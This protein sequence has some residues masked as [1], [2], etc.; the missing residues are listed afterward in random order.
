MALWL[1]ICFSL[2]PCCRLL[3][4]VCASVSNRSSVDTGSWSRPLSSL[5]HMELRATPV[6]F[7]LLSCVFLL[8][9]GGS[10]AFKVRGHRLWCVSNTLEIVP[11]RCLNL[12]IL[13]NVELE[14][15][16]SSPGGS[17]SGGPEILAFRFFV[18][19]ARRESC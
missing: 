3:A 11:I 2:P 10:H 12:G 5:H 15:P 8:P 7:L 1:R 4:S 18:S 9:G 17:D 14:H 13:D 16:Q 6:V 19:E